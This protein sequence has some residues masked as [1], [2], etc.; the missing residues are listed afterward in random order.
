MASIGSA[1]LT[2]VHLSGIADTLNKHQPNGADFK[3]IKAHFSID[4]SGLLS[5][6]TVET[7]FEKVHLPE[8]GESSDSATDKSSDSTSS[9]S[10]TGKNDTA[11]KAEKK[12]KTEILKEE[13]KKEQVVVDVNDLVGAQ[14]ETAVKRIAELNE[15]DRLRKEKEIAQ[16]NLETFI[17][18]TSDK[19]S[20]SEFESVTTEAERDKILAKCSQISDWLYDDDEVE[21]TA[22]VYNAKLKELKSLTDGMYDRHREHRDRPEVVAAFKNALNVSNHFMNKLKDAPADEKYLDDDDI[23]SLETLLTDNQSWLDKKAAEQDK[24]PMYEKPVFTI[25][26][27]AD[28][29]AAMDREVKFLVNKAKLNRTK[30]L[31]ELADK[32]K[33][34]DKKAA[35][36]TEDDK[37]SDKTKESPVEPEPVVEPGVEP[38]AEPTQKPRATQEQTTHNPEL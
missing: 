34:F 26:S 3:G 27:V 33:E 12:P 9:N 5:L 37:A 22:A 31:K 25:K 36:K 32:L 21:R 23:D 15:K 28:K 38:T 19:L 1:N 7:T 29:M 18:D 24:A 14:F 6:S 17:L 2:Q 16:N 8:E 10:S 20:Q 4:D 11:A 30:R 13:L 35:N